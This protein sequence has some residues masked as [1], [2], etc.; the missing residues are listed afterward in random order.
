MAG[1]SW[2]LSHEPPCGREK[3]G[4]C[5]TDKTVERERERGTGKGKK[6]LSGVPVLVTQTLKE[7]ADH[8]KL[9][10]YLVAQEHMESWHM[11]RS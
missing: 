1:K 4:T 9:L 6:P 7:N 10:E 11:R 5:Y 2:Q 8:V 3:E